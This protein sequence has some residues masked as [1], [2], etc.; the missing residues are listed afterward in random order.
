MPREKLESLK[1]SIER[2]GFVEPVVVDRRRGRLWTKDERGDVIV[3]GHQRVRAER[4][5]GHSRVP[6]VYVD[7][8]PESEQTLNLALNSGGEWDL[9]KLGTLLK[10]LRQAGADLA[11][12]GFSDGE[13][14]RAIRVAERELAVPVDEDEVPPP[15]RKA[16]TMPGEL[17]R[18]GPH[19]LLCGDSRDPDV[20]ARMPRVIHLINC[21]VVN[22]WQEEM[23]QLKR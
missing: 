2:F 15:P 22:G 11:A 7:L 13:I 4:E 8:N 10:S 17:V 14:E 1:R 18:L 5:L 6:V 12:S 9:E 21:T 19:R 3:G 23:H 20:C 16:R